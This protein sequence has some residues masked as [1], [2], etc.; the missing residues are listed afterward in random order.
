MTNIYRFL[1]EDYPGLW[2]SSTLAFGRCLLSVFT[3]SS[4]PS[5]LAIALPCISGPLS[6]TTVSSHRR[7]LCRTMCYK[8]FSLH[9]DFGVYV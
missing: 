4:L 5:A 9:Y 1:C 7:T 2:A 6:T 3:H 8:C